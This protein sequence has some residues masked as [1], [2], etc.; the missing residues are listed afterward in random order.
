M[1]LISFLNLSHNHRYKHA[2]STSG[3]NSLSYWIVKFIM[4]L[5]S[6]FI[7]I[8]YTSNGVLLTPLLTVILGA[9]TPLLIQQLVIQKP[10]AVSV[11]DDE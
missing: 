8:L 3:T 6:G 1:E 4:V 10:N 9:S 11:T 2:L 5:I 7:V